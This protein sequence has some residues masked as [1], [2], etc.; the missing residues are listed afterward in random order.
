MCAASQRAG[1]LVKHKI[2][3]EKGGAG[4]IRWQV[5]FPFLFVFFGKF[6]DQI[7]IIII[8]VKGMQ[9]VERLASVLLESD[10]VTG[11]EWTFIIRFVC[12]FILS[13]KK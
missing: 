13:Q 3:G 12:V 1:T 10:K 5:D 8:V 7:Q 6:V 9:H 11:V 2:S 4:K